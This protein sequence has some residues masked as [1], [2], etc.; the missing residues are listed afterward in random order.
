[1]RLFIPGA[2]Y[3]KRAFQSVMHLFLLISAL[4]QFPAAQAVQLISAADC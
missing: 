4:M 2:A 1:M 3:L